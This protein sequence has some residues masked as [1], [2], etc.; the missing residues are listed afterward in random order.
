MLE[1]R[2]GD[3]QSTDPARGELMTGG[4]AADRARTSSA[5]R[6][7]NRTSPTVRDVA[8]RAGVSIATVSRALTGSGS[9]TPELRDRVLAA[10]E[11]LAYNV[12]LLG[13]A[14]RQKRTF[15]LGLVV[16]DLENPFFSALAQQVSRSFGQSAIDVYIYSAD[17]DLRTERRGIQSFLGR[18][19]DGMV[20]IPCDE[21]KSAA[22]V[23]LA[24]RSVVTVQL[25]RVVRSVDTHYVGCDNQ[26]GIGLIV[27]HLHRDADLQRQPV[28]FV[29]AAPTSSSAH[30]R[31]DAFTRAFPES[32]RLLGS[33][34]FAWG[35]QA[36]KELIESGVRAATI[37]TAADIIA[38]GVMAAAQAEGFK[39]PDD[40]RVTGF[41]DFGFSYLAYP[42]LTTVRQTID[43]MMDAI[44]DIVLS[45]L[46]GSDTPDRITRKFTPQLVIRDSSPVNATRVD[47]V[48]QRAAI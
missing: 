28:I 24:N 14:L 47:P 7:G 48:E 32:R 13:R 31:L 11:A 2:N 8:A 30:E 4:R 25:D 37:V 10:A 44:V 23:E 12:N 33:F 40:F 42:P 3:G 39:V 9:V 36:T 6:S 41:D 27:E 35:R 16:P 46:A 15:S 45:R 34:S 26:H 5:A 1:V 18:Q 43:H 20:V 19:V 22:N 38:L 29:G 21:R 17:N